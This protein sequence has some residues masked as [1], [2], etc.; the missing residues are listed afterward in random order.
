MKEDHWDIEIEGNPYR[1]QMFSATS[2]LQILLKSYQSAGS[3]MIF[4]CRMVTHCPLARCTGGKNKTGSC[5]RRLAGQVV[6]VALFAKLEAAQ[7]SS[8]GEAERKQT[9]RVHRYCFRT[10]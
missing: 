10:R 1:T 9:P 4:Q 6:E 3:M 5:Y 7:V 2:I 8:F